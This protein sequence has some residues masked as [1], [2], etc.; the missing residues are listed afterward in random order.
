MNAPVTLSPE[1]LSVASVPEGITATL[2]T[3][4]DQWMKLRQPMVTASV[5]AC[6]FGPIHPYQTAY[7]L[8][9]AKSGLAVADKEETPAMRRGRLMEPVILQMLREDYPTWKIEQC[10][11]FYSDTKARIGATP[12]FLAIRPDMPGFGIIQSK[13]VGK[14]AF[15]K[16][17]KDLDGDVSIPLWVLVQA[18][19]EAGLSGASWACTAPVALGDGG[20]DLYLEDVPLRPGT[21]PKLREL[22]ADFW[23]RVADERPYP[24]DFGRDAATIA[25]VYSLDDEPEVNLA[26]N[27][28]LAARMTKL[29][30]RREALKTIEK[31]ADAAVKERKTIDTELIYA[32]GNAARGRL[33]DGRVVEAKITRRDGFEVAP[34]SYRVV[35]IKEAK[36]QGVAA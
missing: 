35:K 11:R 22:V 14:Y 9:A 6:L 8:W 27:P 4:R 17:W 7:G 29:V 19:I 36:A 16:G 26:S 24:P 34:T 12:D 18:S 23:D 3:D 32:L 33:S 21:M 5:A 20:F 10:R 1:A 13:S 28:E 15:S 25:K 31:T 30:A 2:I